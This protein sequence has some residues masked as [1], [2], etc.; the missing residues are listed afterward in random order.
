M[1]VFNS[2]VLEFFVFGFL[3]WRYLVFDF[4]DLVF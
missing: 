4:V 3:F 1:V 2:G